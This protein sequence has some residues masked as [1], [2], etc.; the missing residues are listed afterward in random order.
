MLSPSEIAQ[1]LKPYLPDPTKRSDLSPVL[2]QYLDLLLKWNSRTNLTAIR[3]PHEIVQRHFGESLFAASEIGTTTSLL[4]LGSG[5]GFPGVPIQLVHPTISIT[6]AES[7]GKKAA[8]LQELVRT[9]NLPTQVWP[10]RAELLPPNLLFDTVTL[11]AVDDMPTALT[12][13]ARCAVHRILILTT[14]HNTT[15]AVPSRRT[16]SRSE[17]RILRARPAAASIESQLPGFTFR[18]IPIPKSSSG[19]LLI[20]ERLPTD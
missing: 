12:E 11:R 18:T 1:L 9:L 17:D 13:A 20:A 6:L 16:G 4:D 10:R 14:S 2:A 5:A 7:Q 15:A 3:N 8:F 19:I